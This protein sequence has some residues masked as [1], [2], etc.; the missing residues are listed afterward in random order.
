MRELVEQEGMRLKLVVVYMV[1]CE[2]ISG[3]GYFDVL[4]G[5]VPCMSK[6]IRAMLSNAK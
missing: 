2:C 6:L 1:K 3:L 5:S 4:R